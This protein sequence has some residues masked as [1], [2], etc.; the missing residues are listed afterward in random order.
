M[1]WK[2]MAVCGTHA[3]PGELSH[4]PVTEAPTGRQVFCLGHC[5]ELASPN[6]GY[7]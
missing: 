2:N 7:M 4:R 6:S 5:D 1:T 3:V